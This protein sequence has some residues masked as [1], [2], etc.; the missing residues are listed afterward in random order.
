MAHKV[1]DGFQWIHKG[2]VGS[3]RA[4]ANLANKIGLYQAQIFVAERTGSTAC[5]SIKHNHEVGLHQHLNV[6][7]P[8]TIVSGKIKKLHNHTQVC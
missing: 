3:L 2:E 6:N 7:T 4:A 8:S 1:F 5:F